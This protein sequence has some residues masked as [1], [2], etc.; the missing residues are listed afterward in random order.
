MTFANQ[1]TLLQNANEN[2]SALSKNSYPG[3]GIII[4]MDAT[5]ENLVQVYWIMGRSPESRNRIFIQEAGGVLRTVAADPNKIKDGRQ[6]QYS[7]NKLT[8]GAPF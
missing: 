2:L 1:K 6:Y 5:G 8:N 7:C 4:G 3:R